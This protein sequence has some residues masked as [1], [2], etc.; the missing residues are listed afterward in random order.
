MWAAPANVVQDG[1]SRIA[2]YAGGSDRRNF[3]LGQT[4][5]DYDAFVRHEN[6]DE[7]G[8]PRLSTASADEDLQATLQ[9]VVLT[10]DPVSGRRIYVNGRFT[11]DVDPIEGGN[12]NDWDDT[13]AFA[14]ASEVD[15]DNRWA[16]TIRM[17]A[18]HNRV[19]TAEQ[20]QQNFEAGVGERYFML[21]N[22]SDH[23]DVDDAYVVFEVSQFDSYSYLF[24]EPFFTILDGD[25][26]P[27]SFP[28]SGMRIGA[29]GREITVGQAYQNINMNIDD[30][31]YTA[32]EGMLPI[33]G[34]GTVVPLEKGPSLD[35]FFLTFEQLGDATNVVVEADPVAPPPPADQPR[36]PALGIRDFAEVHAT[37][38]KVTGIPANNAEVSATYD[39]VRQAMP[40]GTGLGGF[41]SSQ[42]MGVTQL[43]IKYCSVLVDDSAARSSYFPGFDFNADLS[44]AFNDRSLVIDPLMSNMVG[45]GLADQPGVV[46]L[47]GEI[48]DL[49]DRLSACGGSCEADR[50][51]R[52]VK[53]ACAAVLGSA[54]MMVQ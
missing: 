31:T 30:A 40:V 46:E 53:A 19:L 24:N 18:V 14:L 25:A 9:H 1:P 11:D 49:I 50:T 5:Y 34:L 38:S 13:F 16:G 29:N 20:I 36:D 48:N 21:F 4:Q 32:S 39:L 47:S 10:Y 27:G 33:S 42:Q 23:V 54:A 22:V 15:N 37:M 3:M 12:L 35:E 8:D 26:T 41:V 17:V 7:N 45:N 44:T 6:T 2:S 28:L 52:I 43:A 51:E